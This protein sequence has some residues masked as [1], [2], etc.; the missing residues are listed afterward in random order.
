MADTVDHQQQ[1]IASSSRNVDEGERPAKR[2]KSEG[3]KQVVEDG[4]TAEAS[5]PPPPLPSSDALID[6]IPPPPPPSDLLPP[7]PPADGEEPPPPPPPAID[8]PP[9]PP[10]ES[11]PSDYDDSQEVESAEYWERAAKEDKEPQQNVVRDL[12]L[13]TINRSVLDFDFE[14]L[15]SISLSNLNVYSCLVCGKYYQGRGKS[16]H[17][18]FHSIDE[19]HRVYMNLET[20]KVYIL[21]DN[22]E[23]D[24]PAL[25]DIKFLL[26]PTYTPTQIK[27]LDAPN[28]R[29][30]LDLQGKAY[31]PG[32]VGLNNIGGNDYMNV[33]IQALSHVGP[34]RDCLLGAELHS[35]D[36]GSRPS[37]T[38]N[39][40]AASPGLTTSVNLAKSSEL[41]RRFASV[42]RKLWNPRAFKAQV[43]PHELL[44]EVVSASKGRFRLMEQGDPVEFLGWL[45]N[46]LHMDLNGG[47]RRKP[48]IISACFQGEV[49][50]ESQ[51]VF[52]K[53]GLEELEQ[54]GMAVDADNLDED[55][56]K[57]AGQE[58]EEGNARFNFNESIKVDRSPFFLLA[59]DLPAPPVFQDVIEKNIIPQVS[60]AEVLSKY[61]GISFQEARGI[62]RRYKVLRLPPFLILHFKRF[63]KNNFVEERNPTIVNFPIAG[64]D[65]RDYVEGGSDAP[66][67]CVYD[68]VS[69]ITHEA[70]AG[71]VRE[72]AIWRAQAHTSLDGEPLPEGDGT[73]MQ[74][75]NGLSEANGSRKREEKWFQ[76]QDL[77]VEEINRQMIFLSETYIQIWRRK[78]GPAGTVGQEIERTLRASKP[79]ATDG[80]SKK[81]K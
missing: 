36:D 67:S 33:V 60:I 52:V 71:T 49:R 16:S 48:S 18:Y 37:S 53:T 12:Y 81:T 19:E 34:L 61:D 46:Q 3:L 43:S 76:M 10:D 35:T 5:Q 24:S 80:Q 9:P 63:T 39:T 2:R 72:N 57:D 26:Q 23:V 54:N 58:D 20:A 78:D 28:A 73:E 27:R 50:V 47:S 25:T 6:D 17:A 66:L 42:L 38:S 13:D 7:P 65:L 32:K 79:K 4:D 74:E 15:C 51:Q 31:L 70:T 22:Y 45:L 69:N 44:Q 64:L 11:I 75:A 8:A 41:A 14:K 77:V 21:P 59:L 68:L 55:G 56:R 1:P 30:S 29:P 40:S 62:I